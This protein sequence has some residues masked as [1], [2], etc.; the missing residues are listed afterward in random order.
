MKWI[1]YTTADR[2]V[3]HISEP[4]FTTPPDTGEADVQLDIN[5]FKEGQRLNK[6]LT[7]VEPDP[8]YQALVD[9]ETR[10]YDLIRTDS[11]VTRVL[12]DL[13]DLLVSKTLINESELPQAAQDKLQ[14]R[15]NLRRVR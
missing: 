8:K 11:A 5:S 7:D 4:P 9:E 2:K 10:K 14:E 12:E 15:R 3:L 6:A 1:R 13:I